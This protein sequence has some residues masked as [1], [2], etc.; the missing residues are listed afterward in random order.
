MQSGLQRPIGQSIPD[1]RVIHIR[2][3]GTA[4]AKPGAFID[5]VHW[6]LFA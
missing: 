5:L 6:K 2:G 1:L 4:V 3:S